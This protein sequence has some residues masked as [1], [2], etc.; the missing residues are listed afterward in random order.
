MCLTLCACMDFVPGHQ[1]GLDHVL[2]FY[3]LDTKSRSRDFIADSDTYTCQTQFSHDFINSPD[4]AKI[5]M[6]L[7][8]KDHIFL[9][10]SVINRPVY[11][12]YVL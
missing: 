8:M 6:G 3:W 2:V 12:Q 5:R 7:F 11:S 1:A 4:V 10:N 9:S